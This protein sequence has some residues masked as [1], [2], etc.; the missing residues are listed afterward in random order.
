MFRDCTR[1]GTGWYDPLGVATLCICTGMTDDQ[2][3]YVKS[4]HEFIVKLRRAGQTAMLD[5]DAL[6]I[7]QADVLV[8]M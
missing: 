6:T 4:L 1:C 5:P 2:A 3:E 7:E 8:G